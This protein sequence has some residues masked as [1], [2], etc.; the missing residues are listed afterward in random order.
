MANESRELLQLA[1]AGDRQALERLVE[2]HQ[3][4]LLAFVRARAGAEL[5]AY[6]SV[7]DIL[8]DVLLEFVREVAAFEYRGESEFRGWL[9]T[10]AERRIRDRA[11][12]HRREKRAR[13]H[14]RSLDDDAARDALLSEGYSS[15][16]GVGGDLHR[17]DDLRRLEAAFA[18]LPAGDR[19]VLSLAYFCNMS[20]RTIAEHLGVTEEVAR[21]R[22]TRARTRLAGLWRLTRL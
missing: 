7:R 2:Q 5:R 19:E 6:E 13:S 14:Q 22:R 3:P 18:R 4:S 1:A 8:Q 16:P 11:R 17:T 12:Y 21:K 9:Y 10:L 20:S 15:L